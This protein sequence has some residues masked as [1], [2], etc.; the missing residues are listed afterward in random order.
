MEKAE[1]AS[2]DQRSNRRSLPLPKA[3]PW[4]VIPYGKGEKFQAFY[5][6]SEP[7][8]T[9]CRKFIPELKGKS[10]YQKN[11][12]QGWL[13]VLCDDDEFD[14]TPWNYGDC[15]L[16]NPLTMESIEL[17]S[18]LYWYTLDGY[19]LSD[20]LLTS[21]P[22]SSSTSAT[23]EAGNGNSMVFMLFRRE[24]KK[25]KAS[26]L[27]CHPG[28][29]KWRTYMIEDIYGVG[30]LRSMCYFKGKLYIMCFGD[31]HLEIEIQHEL[32]PKIPSTSKIQVSNDV[33]YESMGGVLDSQILRY[34]VETSDEIFMIDK[35]FITRGVY[36]YCVTIMI[37]L[38]LDFSTMSWV[39]VTSLDDHVLF[40]SRTTRLSCSARGL[41]FTQGCVY[42]TQPNE[43]C[44][45][46][47][48][49]EDKSVMLSLPC[50]ELP[51]PWFPPNWLMIPTTLRDDDDRRRA[52]DSM[53]GNGSNNTKA[54]EKSSVAKKTI[55]RRTIMNNDDEKE[56][57]KE[58]KG[59]DRLDD[60][61]VWFISS[62]LSLLD[63]VHLRAVCRNYRLVFPIVNWRSCCSTR[64]LQS[65]VSSPWLVFAKDNESV[66]S[67]INPMHKDEN[68]LTSI[69]EILEGSTI[70]F[71]K[72]GWL[73]LSKGYLSV[74]FYNPFTKAIIKLPDLPSNYQFRGISF[75]SL[76]TSSDCVVFAISNFANDS[77][78]ISF[79]KRGDEF[80]TYSNQYDNVYLPPN[81]TNMDFEPSLNSPIFYKGAFYCLDVNGTLGVF[82]LENGTRWE[83][84]SMVPPPNCDFI[85]KSYLVELEGKLLSVLLGHYG[86]WVRVFRLD[87]TEMVWVEVK[88]L[89]RLVLFI[90]NT[91]CMATIAPTSRME[92]RIYFPRLQNEGILFYSLDSGEY[93]S[94]ESENYGTD[95]CNSKDNLRCGWIEPTLSET[96]LPNF[97]WSS[98]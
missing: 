91:S 32:E 65:T 48:A 76:P 25:G 24:G 18:F 55:S 26:L 73:L 13:I 54:V 14:Y 94:L 67:F 6:F 36:Q 42:F 74:F 1:L 79:I 11:S 70:R 9:N 81:R 53:S 33:T 29:E 2:T 97:D 38:K 72:G 46:K 90:S 40:I 45:Y 22:K 57:I 84:L 41:G 19:C 60:D 43:M 88:H 16:L 20:C 64:S 37:I 89:G 61:I 63:Y 98:I 44:F 47:Y 93:H 85:Y 83:V 50:P 86:K 27:F 30:E 71:S 82:T 78:F 28:D 39:E 92:N 68:Y 10:A 5:N 31:E 58:V 75:S 21:P 52:T 56:D 34:Y 15:F 17:P 3:A 23:L 49:L 77:V 35:C 62:C 4:L 69:P 80:W 8:N 95:Y 51:K 87:M 12:H 7:N 96:T 59:W 66:Y